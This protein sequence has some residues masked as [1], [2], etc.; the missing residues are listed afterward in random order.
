M[1]DQVEPQ[2]TGLVWGG[3][4][5]RVTDRKARGPQTEERGCK[6]QIFLSFS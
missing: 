6:Y 5:E 2:A 4:S 1:L 3:T